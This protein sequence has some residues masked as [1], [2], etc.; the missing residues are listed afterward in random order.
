M[1]INL[2]IYNLSDYHFNEVQAFFSKYRINKI[3]NSSNDLVKLNHIKIEHLIKISIESFLN[4]SIDNLTFITN[5]YGKPTLL[6]H[7]CFISIS[8]KEDYLVI[9]ISNNDLGVDIEK[10]NSKYRNVASKI[11]DEESFNKYNN[12]IDK[13][14]KDWTILESFVKLIGK[15]MYIDLKSL[16]LTNN[17]IIDHENNT[18]YYEN[19]KFKNNYYIT[20]ASNLE[21]Q[22]K[23]NK[24]LA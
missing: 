22:L 13:I 4:K 12:N 24:K 7:N 3:N 6:N 1:D 23:I 14:I 11:Y 19:I 5:E 10:I 21:F 17:Q 20:V 8:H 18:Y 15:N 16:K 2:F 9:A